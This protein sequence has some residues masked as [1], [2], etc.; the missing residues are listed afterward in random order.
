ALST[1]PAPVV[2]LASSR[3]TGQSDLTLES[4]TALHQDVPL[5]NSDTQTDPQAPSVYDDMLDLTGARI[6]QGNSGGPVL[7]AS[8]KVVGIVTLSS[9]GTAEAFAIPLSRVLAELQSFERRA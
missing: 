5:S 8:G 7:D 1:T 9:P 3:A 4:L 6:Y 2:V